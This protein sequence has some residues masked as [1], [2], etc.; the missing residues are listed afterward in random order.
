MRSD[1]LRR[2][3][4][5]LVAQ[6][7][8][9]SHCT[10]SCTL[11]SR[12]NAFTLVELLVTVTIISIL[13]S[14]LI[15]SITMARAAARAATCSSNLR[16]FGVGFFAYAERNNGSL[17]S[18]AFD[19]RRDGAVTDIGWVADMVDGGIP[20]GEML[21]VS[22]DSQLSSTYKDLLK[23]TV[24][25]SDG[26]C[27]DWLGS[28]PKTLPDGTQESNPCRTIAT[29]NR[30]EERRV[31]VEQQIFEKNFNTNYAASW[32]LVRSQPRLDASGNLVA[33]KAGCNADILSR[34]SSYGPL[35]LTSLEAAPVASSFV[36]LLGCARAA[37]M[38]LE[39]QI[40]PN[41]PGTLLAQSFTSGP[42]LRSSFSTPSFSAGTSR[43]GAS[44]WW[45]QW[46]GM[47][48]TSGLPNTMQDYRAFNPIHRGICNVLMGD[49]SVKKLVDQNGDGAL[50]NG[51]TSPKSG[52]A[53]ANPEIS[54]DDV[55]SKAS[56]RG[57]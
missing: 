6:A 2:L 20:V 22:N 48:A 33:D 19:W 41:G 50:N 38:T 32:L 24:K 9:D 37:A 39:D 44:G 5:K 25:A 57:L 3:L 29:M 18:G 34:N 35:N 53:D 11:A 31:I 13:V 30:G 8:M 26:D 23:L 16:Q 46:E 17:C 51:F 43:N 40:G 21:C 4:N 27:V 45:A 42:K 10:W 1:I 7:K 28:A 36:P 12:R 56:L 55:F 14:I 54:P 15:P 49:G 47:D 52:F